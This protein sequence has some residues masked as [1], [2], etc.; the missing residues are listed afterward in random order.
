[1]EEQTQEKLTL[2]GQENSDNLVSSVLKDLNEKR[3]RVLKGFRNSIPSPFVRFRPDFLGIQKRKYYVVTSSTKGA[4]TQFSSY[5]FLY[6]PLFEAIE[7]PD[8]RRIKIFYYSLEDT[9]EDIMLRFMSHLLYRF[10]DIHISPEDLQSVREGKLL[11]LK[12]L[13][14]LDSEKYRKYLDFFESHTE[15]SESSNPTGVWKECIAYAEKHGKSIYR[16]VTIKDDFG[17]DKIIKKFVKYIPDDQEEYVII[18]IDHVSLI[19]QERDLNLKQSIDKLSEYLKTLRNRY[20]YIPVVIQQ[21]AFAGEGLDAIKENKLRPTIANLSDSKYPS[22]DANVVLGLFSPYKFELRDY[23][24]YDITK[25]KD[26]CRFLE[27]IVNRG[28]KMGGIIGLYFN[29]ESCYFEELPQ[30]T[31][32]AKLNEIY[33]R[34]NLTNGNIG[35]TLFTFAKLKNKRRRKHK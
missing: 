31:E 20:G 22:R 16:N 30:T 27:V 14:L 29:G 11:D 18:F 4:K 19:T 28:G 24:G 12:I 21:Q 17:N 34:I 10:D 7:N 13:E 32:Y 1:M 23:K 2:T 15:F 26:N 3:D 8:K 35:R 5:T 6:T 9:P 25:L 33:A